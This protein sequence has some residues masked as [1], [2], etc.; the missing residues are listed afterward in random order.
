M[1]TSAVLRRRPQMGQE[2]KQHA[3]ER[4]AEQEQQGAEEKG[5]IKEGLPC[6]VLVDKKANV[7]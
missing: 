6:R 1:P 3:A 2:E 5:F 7:S 4:A